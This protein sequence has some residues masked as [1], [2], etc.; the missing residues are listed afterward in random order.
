VR[1]DLDSAAGRTSASGV[2]I[3]FCPG[4]AGVC[5]E[6]KAEEESKMT[7]TNAVRGM[8]HIIRN[9]PANDKRNAP[10]IYGGRGVV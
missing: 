8:V 9:C 10:S 1:E 7:Q 3:V 5:E 2:E 4:F 6:R